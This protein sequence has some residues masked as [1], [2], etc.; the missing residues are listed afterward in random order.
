MARVSK[1]GSAIRKLPEKQYAS[2][3]K[4][5]RYK[6]GIY[7]RL[8]SEQGNKLCMQDKSYE[9]RMPKSD[10]I[11]GQI[12][13]A[14]K[15]V[16]EFNQNQTDDII[17]VVSCY[18]D[19]G[20]TGT[21]FDRE[22]FLA[23]LADIRCGRIDCVIVKD[24]SRF[25]RNY[26][27]AGNYIEKIFPFL[28]VRFIA[29]SDG[30]DTGNTK[31]ITEQMADVMEVEI[32]NLVNDMYAKDFSKKAKIQLEQRRKEGSYAGGVPPYGYVTGWCKKRRILIPDDKTMEI[33]R[34]IY[35]RF[36]EAESYTA[37]F[38][39]LNRRKI[40]PPA[41]YRKTGDVYY[42]M[43]AYPSFGKTE[44]KRW[45]RSAVERILSS[46]TY[47]GRLVQGK[48]SISAR[49][50]KNRIHNAKETWVI[51]EDAHEPLIPTELYRKAEK[52][53]KRIADKTAVS[54][55]LTVDCPI[56]ENIFEHILYCGICGRK[57]TRNSHVK[58]YA[59]GTKVR[60]DGY[61]CFN[62][63]QSKVLACHDS[64]R[65][66]KAELTDML[67]HIIRMTFTLLLNEEEKYVEVGNV[68][69]KK[70]IRKAEAALRTAEGSM[71]ILC[72]E[73]GRMY[74]DYRAGK[75]SQGEY[76][77][78]RIQHKE[79]LLDVKNRKEKHQEERKALERGSESYRSAIRTVLELKSDSQL[80]QKMLEAFIARIYVYTGKRIEIV[81]VVADDWQKDKI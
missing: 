36:V 37:V 28:G 27:E 32:K 62:G 66:S 74:M 43:E 72:E 49:N 58:Q 15:F 60:L 80:T 39:E 22:G 63:A 11:E 61:F 71:R 29:V 17:D 23:L 42:S 68:E 53:R 10:S 30:F 55:H 69:M 51:T 76:T 12:A 38:D 41:V 2:K 50:E 7:A 57:M 14:K 9:P 44:Y 24:L 13:I 79:K 70:E 45:D 40:N 8:S 35:E 3:H 81:F 65:I 48:T 20:K 73:E 78:Y 33:V 31:N 4:G 34:L 6:A 46:E 75:I 47:I 64:N 1:R 52:I 77:A 16:E 26:L 21:N 19:L 67:I 18:T 54:R 56:Q 5:K 59:N 25:G